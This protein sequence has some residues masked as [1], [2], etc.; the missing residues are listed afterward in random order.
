MAQ[1]GTVQGTCE[2]AQIGDAIALLNLLTDTI[3]DGKLGPCSASKREA[4]QAQSR[5]G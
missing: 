4:L 1:E 5:H 2:L 3:A